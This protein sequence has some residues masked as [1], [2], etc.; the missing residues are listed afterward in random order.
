MKQRTR[1]HSQGLTVHALVEKHERLCE[2]NGDWPKC[3]PRAQNGNRT[4]QLLQVRPILN[5]RS[6]VQSQDQSDNIFV[7]RHTLNYGRAGDSATCDLG[8]QGR[9]RCNQGDTILRKRS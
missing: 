4:K 8:E 6:R 9:H 5:K 7:A 3:D 1:I 2:H